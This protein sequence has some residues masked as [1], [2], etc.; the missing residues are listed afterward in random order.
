MAAVALGA[1]VPQSDWFDESP[2]VLTPAIPARGLYPFTVRKV[3]LTCNQGRRLSLTYQ[4]M[5]SPLPERRQIAPY[6]LVQDGFR[7][8]AHAFCFRDGIFKDFVVGR[9]A[10]VSLGDTAGIDIATDTAWTETVALRIAPHPVLFLI[11]SAG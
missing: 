11:A 7:W 4:S 9:M 1:P 5:S 8:H 10:N 6:G 2:A 3:L